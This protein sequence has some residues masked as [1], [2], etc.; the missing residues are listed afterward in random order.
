MSSLLLEEKSPESLGKVV[1]EPE[2]YKNADWHYRPRSCRD[3]GNLY[4]KANMVWFIYAPLH[5]VLNTLWL[6]RG[7]GTSCYRIWHHVEHDDLKGNAA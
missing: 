2:M 6:Q 5:K 3:D 7:A 4:T 1:W